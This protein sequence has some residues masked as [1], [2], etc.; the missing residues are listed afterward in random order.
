MSIQ[1]HSV[2]DLRFHVFGVSK[3]FCVFLCIRVIGSIF[4]FVYICEFEFVVLVQLICEDISVYACMLVQAYVGICI[5]LVGSGNYSL[6]V[7]P[8]LKQPSHNTDLLTNSRFC[9]HVQYITMVV[10]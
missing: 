5:S 1:V 2:N 3:C 4:I 10:I 7:S 6:F 9:T 8:A